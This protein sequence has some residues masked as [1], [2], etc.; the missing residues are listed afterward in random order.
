MRSM[1][2]WFKSAHEFT[3]PLASLDFM[4]IW[5]KSALGF[6]FPLA[7][8]DFR[9]TWFKSALGF[10]CSWILRLFVNSSIIPTIALF[11]FLCMLKDAMVCV[12]TW[13][14]W[15][16]SSHG[17]HVLI[18][19]YISLCNVRR[20]LVIE[21]ESKSVIEVNN[22]GQ[23]LWIRWLSRDSFRGLS[24]DEFGPWNEL[25]GERIKDAHGHPYIIG[26]EATSG[27]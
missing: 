7:N 17:I 16:A 10:E 1:S 20:R 27:M 8:L 25:C 11:V 24:K 13:Q 23:G 18:K 5:F 2:T 6:T 4:S 14:S 12:A 19:Q 26:R 3:F 9:S 15:Q 22:G 21:N